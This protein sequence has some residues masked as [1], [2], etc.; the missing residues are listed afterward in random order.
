[1]LHKRTIGSAVF[2]IINTLFA[3][4][5]I[6]ITVYPMLYVLF[7]SVSNPK[8]FMSYSGF[9]WRP[10]GVMTVK[11]YEITMRNPSIII[12]FRNSIFYV[13]VGTTL[14]VL[15]TSVGAFVLTRKHF[16]YRR[17]C[18]ILVVITMFF[19][20]GIIPLFFVVRMLGLY[21]SRWA[22]VFPVLISAY[23]MIIM[24]TFFSSLPDSLEESAGL[25]GANDLQVY[26]HIVMPLSKPVLA[27]MVLFY[28]VY[29]WN[30]WFNA[31][32]Y[33]RDRTMYPLQLFLREILLQDSLE[34]L[35]TTSV[36]MAE[37]SLYRDLIKYC[38]IIVS[39]VPILAIYPFL[40]RYFVKGVMIGAIKG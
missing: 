21:D 16:A 30:S 12:G 26:M 32:I 34:S 33:L 11:G 2:D 9:V 23:N 22:V 28:G 19:S 25:D 40:Q 10:L 27:V 13:V 35:A 24:Q 14:N 31:M 39:T 6:F 38:A 17:F 18:S 29:H 3:M 1:M 20:G 5:M 36:E 37:E 4:L 8:V 15:L 7:A